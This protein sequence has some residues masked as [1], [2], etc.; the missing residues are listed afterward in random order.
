MAW[1]NAP[2]LRKLTAAQQGGNRGAQLWGGDVKGKLHTIYQTSPGGSWSDWSG[3]GWKDS[4][5]P[6]AV[7][8]LAATQSDPDGRV[9]FFAI[10]MKGQMWARWQ[11]SPGGSWLPWKKDFNPVPARKI[12]AVRDKVKGHQIF[13]IT[14]NGYLTR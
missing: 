10:D 12:A 5:E 8:E 11:T 14:P 7:Y 6:P 1:Q 9:Y 4:H 13:V 2:A 3:T